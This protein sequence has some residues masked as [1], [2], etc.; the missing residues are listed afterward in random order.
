MS[1]RTACVVALDDDLEPGSVRL[2]ATEPIWSS[3]RSVVRVRS[4]AGHETVARCRAESSLDNGHVD[5]SSDLAETLHVTAGETV[6]LEPTTATHATRIVAAPVAQLSLNGGESAVREALTDRPVTVGDTVTVSLLRG[7][8]EVPFRVTETDPDGAVIVGPETDL[9]LVPGPAPAPLDRQQTT[10]LPPDAVGGYDATVRELRAAVAD[11]LRHPDAY[12]VGDARG[13]SAAAGVLVHGQRGVGKTQLIRHAA[14]LADAALVSVDCPTLA[15]ESASGAADTLDDAT[16][17]VTTRAPAVVHLDELDVLAEDAQTGRVEQ[18]GTWVERVASRDDAVVVGE[19][20]DPDTLDDALVRGGRLS[21]HV[22]VP[23][24]TDADRAAIL[25]VLMRRLDV[26]STVDP[27][28]VADRTLGYVAADLVTLRARWIEA[29]LDRTDG[30]APTLTAADL[31]T[32]LEA[33]T[34]SAVSSVGSIP[35]TTFDDIGGLDD[36][37]RELV[38]AVEWPLT[39]PEALARLGVDTPAGVLL[40]GPPG[41][42]KT[43]LA[44][45]VASTTQANFLPVNGPELLNKYVGE[46]ERQVR[47]LFDRARDSAPCVVFFDE[48]DALGGARGSDGDTSAPERVVSQLLTELDGLTSREQVTVIGATNRPDRIDEALTRP[49]RFDRL[50]EVPLPDPAARREILRI[51]IQNR[52]FEPIDIDSLVR[53]TEGYSG[54][55]IAAML[56]EASLLALEERLAAADRGADAVD[57]A[58]ADDLVVRRRHVVRALSQVGPSLSAEQRERYASFGDDA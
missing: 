43:M 48:I 8:F 30:T 53:E 36:V 18:V 9:E 39:H 19:T 15:T 22:S 25:A 24:P 13:P 17:A 31:D 3:D 23:P 28:A 1:N 16:R 41:T 52:P 20:R 56:Q 6:V 37:K 29:A 5:L 2:A 54:S 33:T 38:R 44:R 34:P 27:D 11:P 50:V 51:H 55:D 32:A 42:G 26:D 14:W 21:R 7:T 58:T 46:S 12:R 45:A 10:P 57:P 47:Q 49:G 40:Y 4:P 35:S